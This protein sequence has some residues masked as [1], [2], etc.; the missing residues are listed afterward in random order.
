M[1]HSFL[2]IPLIGYCHKLRDVKSFEM[3]WAAPQE[4]STPNDGLRALD[5]SFLH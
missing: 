1:R 2:Q 5:V 3:A 4:K